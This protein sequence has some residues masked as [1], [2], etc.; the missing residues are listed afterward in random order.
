MN[1]DAPDLFGYQPDL[2]EAEQAR[3]LMGQLLIE[4]RLYRKSREYADV[5]AICLQTVRLRPIQRDVV[6]HTK[7]GAELHGNGVRLV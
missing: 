6:A 7:A 3:S 5:V 1:S 2:F 4:S